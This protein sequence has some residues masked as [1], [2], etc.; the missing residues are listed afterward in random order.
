M[1]YRDLEKRTEAI[2]KEKGY[3][4]NPAQYAIK[5]LP[6]GK[7]VSKKLDHF[8]CFDHQFVRGKQMRQIQTCHIN[9][10]RQHQRKIDKLYPIYVGTSDYQTVEIW[11]YY[12]EKGK[13]KIQYLRR[14][15]KDWIDVTNMQKLD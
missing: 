3:L 11:A 13:W 15:W 9:K 2:M 4:S 5:R 12:K 10:V 6:S 14:L 7:I 8:H 1:K